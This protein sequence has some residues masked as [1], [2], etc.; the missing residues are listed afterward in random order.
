MKR[1]FLPK[2]LLW[3]GLLVVVFVSMA[4][5]CGSK[6]DEVKQTGE[7]VTQIAAKNNSAL[8]GQ[9]LK[10]NGRV[11]GVCACIQVCNGQGENC[12]ACVCSPAGCGSC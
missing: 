2:P 11:N 9:R 8:A 5:N 4:G 12:T 3:A 6:G 1:F 7:A 10:F